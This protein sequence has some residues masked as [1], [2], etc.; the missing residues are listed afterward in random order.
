MHVALDLVQC[1]HPLPGT[2]ANAAAE[3]DGFAP[4]NPSPAINIV[5][6]ILRIGDV[7]TLP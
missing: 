3:E 4:P 1:F 6:L 2:R 7:E 5:N